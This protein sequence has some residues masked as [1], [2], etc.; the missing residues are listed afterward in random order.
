MTG[1]E[2]FVYVTNILR[3]ESHTENLRKAYGYAYP[4]AAQVREVTVESPRPESPK[5]GGADKG[6]LRLPNRERQPSLVAWGSRPRAPREPQYAP[7]PTK[8]VRD[9]GRVVR[10]SLRGRG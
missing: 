10:V 2:V 6:S 3:A 4:G 7:P 1:E 9:R 5:G 8:G